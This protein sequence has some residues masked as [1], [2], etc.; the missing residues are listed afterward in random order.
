V[1]QESVTITI[2]GKD[3][4]AIPRAAYLRMM[5]GKDL[6]GTVDAVEYTR[7]R[8]GETL[9]AARDAAGLTQ[10]QLA[11]KLGKKQPMVSGAESGSV[12]VGARFVANVLKACGLPKDW[13][14][15]KKR[16]RRRG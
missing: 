1:G 16:G 15:P 11:K 2:D 10:D 14:A 12:R 4:V 3:Y 5:G 13:K 7:K 8:L 9:R 6:E